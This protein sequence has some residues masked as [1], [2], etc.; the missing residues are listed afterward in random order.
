LR[1]TDVDVENVVGVVD[2]EDGVGRVPVDGERFGRRVG[3]N[4]RQN[5]K[6]RQK[7][8]SIHFRTCRVSCRFRILKLKMSVKFIFKWS[9]FFKRPT[10]EICHGRVGVIDIEIPKY[11]S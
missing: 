8:F 1:V 5:E 6:D 9:N 2:P 3:Q 4:R 10:L 11:I 7:N